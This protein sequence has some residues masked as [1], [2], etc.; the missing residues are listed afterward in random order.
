[1]SKDNSFQTKFALDSLTT[2]PDYIPSISSC[3]LLIRVR[4]AMKDVPLNSWTFLKCD[5]EPSESQEWCLPHRSD[6]QR[7]LGTIHFGRNPASLGASATAMLP[8]LYSI[9]NPHNFSSGGRRISSSDLPK[10]RTTSA[11]WSSS[12]SYIQVLQ[13][14]EYYCLRVLGQRHRYMHTANSHRRV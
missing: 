3:F 12:T 14:G 7:D 5:G 9:P 2:P 10:H 11:G 6:C 1:V 8:N 13:D 4:L